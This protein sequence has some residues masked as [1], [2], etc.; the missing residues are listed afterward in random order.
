MAGGRR[1]G[2]V[3][4][5]ERVNAAAQLVEAGVPVAEAARVLAG[6]FSVSV[7]QARRYVDRA[8]GAGRVPVPEASVV[9]TVKLPAVLAERVRA[10]ARENQTT[11]S[12]VVT[13]ALTEFVT[14]GRRG[15]P[16]R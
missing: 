11:I 8:A 10:H 16:G 15:H 9:F 14:R 1:V 6:R 3:E 4:H 7:R 12:A 13:R 2:G 5:A